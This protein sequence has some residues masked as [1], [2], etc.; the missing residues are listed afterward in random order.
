MDGESITWIFLIGGV[1]LMLL[2][3]VVPGGIAFVLGLSGLIV[4]AL[5]YIGFLEDPLTSLSVWLVSSMALTILIRPIMRKFLPGDT[6]FKLADED[7]EAMD[8]VVKV[9]EPIND[10]DNSGR[11]R[12][13]GISWQARSMEGEIPAGAEVRIKYREST[14]WIVE[15][16]DPIQPSGIQQ[17]QKN[18]N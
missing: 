8:Q 6:S 3:M 1:L 10:Q 14:T 18:K 16:I 5:R 9:V 4:G 2:E 11:I 13:N 7:F 15:A 12:Y 17:K